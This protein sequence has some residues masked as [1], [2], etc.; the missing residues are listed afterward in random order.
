ME[1]ESDDA[2]F[3]VFSDEADTDASIPVKTNSSISINGP[4]RLEFQKDRGA[5]EKGIRLKEL[6]SLTEMSDPGVRYF[7]GT[8]T[9]RTRF[10]VKDAKNVVELD[11]GEVKNIAE[12]ILNGKNL[13][14]VWKTPFVLNVEDVIR[15][16][17]N[18]LEI[19]ITNTW[20]NRLIGDAQSDTEKAI[21]YTAFQFYKA[22]DPL[23][24]SGL[25]GPV[26]LRTK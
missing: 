22:E 15:K 1:F 19:R 4:W 5:P 17:I 10:N 13:G 14:V 9:Y 18:T 12:V 6:K 3:I 21:T 16:G 20:P 7:S 24:P 25:L 2:F 11:L 26:T 8:V 23:L